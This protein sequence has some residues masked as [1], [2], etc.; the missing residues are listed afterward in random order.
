MI[1]SD[2]DRWRAANQLIKQHGCKALENATARVHEAAAR[3][4]QE[5]VDL[6]SDVMEKIVALQADPAANN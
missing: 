1:V 2:L 4:S 3:G 6:W 5:G